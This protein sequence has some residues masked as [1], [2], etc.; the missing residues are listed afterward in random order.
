[1]SFCNDFVWGAAT[2]AY[3]VEGAAFEDG[4]GQNIWDEFSHVKGKTFQGETGDISCDQYH[5]YKEDVGLMKEIGIK[6]Y[7]FSLNWARILPHG[8]GEV[9]E[10][11]IAYYNALIDELLAN[12]IEPYITLYH[13]DLPYELH[14][15][16]GFLNP[17]VEHW[18]YE[19]A[20]VVAENFSDRVTNYF[21]LNEPQCT[22]GLGYVS[23]KHAPGLSVSSKEFFQIQYHVLRCHGMCVRALREFSKQPVKIGLASCGT[24]Y[25]PQTESPEDIENTRKYTFERL[26]K[27]STDVIWNIAFIMDPIILGDYSEE[28]KKKYKGDLVTL[29]EEDKKLISMPLDFYGQN[30]YHVSMIKTGAKGAPEIVK[31]PQGCAL[32]TKDWTV[33]PEG[34]YWLP[35]F[36]WER[37]HL[38]IYITENGTSGTDWV[39]LDGKVHDAFRTDFIHRYLLQLKKA[40]EDGVEIRGYFHWSLMDNFEWADGYSKRFGLIYVDYQTQKRTIK[41]SAYFYREVIDTNGERL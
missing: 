29:T 21:T 41:D 15:K 35:K 25:Y 20:R 26:P 1:M 32:T 33:T 24:G 39:S 4:K 19:Y 23:G 31:N 28:M 40:A 34:L 16:G 30:I 22:I 17:E 38:P 5:R 10:Q 11:G 2:A 27:K 36:L 13:W 37:Y 9:N 8:T 12:G 7:R 18:F 14:L 6:A 3:Q